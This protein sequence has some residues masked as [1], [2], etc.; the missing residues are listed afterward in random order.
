LEIL[1]QQSNYISNTS[2]VHPLRISG[3][4][5]CH[6]SLLSL[7]EFAIRV[8]FIVGFNIPDKLVG[9]EETGP[10]MAIGQNYIVRIAIPILVPAGTWFPITRK[11]RICPDEPLIVNVRP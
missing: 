2:E 1:V 8:P 9:R 5:S 6:P 10:M 7:Y 3:L 11:P 4:S